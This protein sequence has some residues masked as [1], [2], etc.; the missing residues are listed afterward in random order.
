MRSSQLISVDQLILSTSGFI[1]QIKGILTIKGYKY[2]TVFV[3]K[4]SHFT[5]THLQKTATPDENIE[6]KHPLKGCVNS[7]FSRWRH[8]ILTAAY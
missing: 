7:M 2:A 3:Y 1:P 8:T 4:Y 6:G 5:C